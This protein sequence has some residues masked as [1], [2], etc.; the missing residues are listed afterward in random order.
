MYGNNIKKDKLGRF[1]RGVH[2]SIKTEFKIGQEGYW[3]GKRRS[4]K[5]KKKMSDSLKGRVSPNK[6]KSESRHSGSFL[7]SHKSVLKSK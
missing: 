4:E 3:K 6:E 5:T 2:S 1:I 7:K